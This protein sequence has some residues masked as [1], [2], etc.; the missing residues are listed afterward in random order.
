MCLLPYYLMFAGII[1]LVEIALNMLTDCRKS[2][3]QRCYENSICFYKFHV[4]NRCEAMYAHVQTEYYFEVPHKLQT[5][6]I[7]LI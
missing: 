5:L 7:V 4:C 1:K 6:L 3:V 2:Q